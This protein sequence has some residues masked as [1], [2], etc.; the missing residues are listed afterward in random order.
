MEA[1][2]LRLL[3][4]NRIK[5]KDRQPISAAERP[6]VEENN[7]YTMDDTNNATAEYGVGIDKYEVLIGSVSISL[8]LRPQNKTLPTTISAPSSPD[9]PCV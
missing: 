6:L 3:P 4:D 9:T 2:L 1:I 8:I 7:I 5:I